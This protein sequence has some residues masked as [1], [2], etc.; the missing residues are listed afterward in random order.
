MTTIIS[1]KGFIPAGRKVFTLS[2]YRDVM[3][4]PIKYMVDVKNNSLDSYVKIVDSVPKNKE[5]NNTIS[6]SIGGGIAISDTSNKASLN[7][8]YVVLKSISYV[9][10]DIIQYKLMIR[11]ALLHG[12]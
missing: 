3:I 8:N 5:V 6:Y 12:I 7:E 10:P 1:I 11:I 4:W 2:K 9:Q